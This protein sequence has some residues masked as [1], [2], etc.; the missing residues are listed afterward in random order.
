MAEPI[1]SQFFV[2]P[3]MMPGKV[4]ESEELQKFA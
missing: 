3:H 1:E 4:Y 2:G